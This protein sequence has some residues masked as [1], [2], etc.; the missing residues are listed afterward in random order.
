MFGGSNSGAVEDTVV[1]G[2]GD[3]LHRCVVNEVGIESVF[4]TG[5]KKHVVNMC[6]RYAVI[7]ELV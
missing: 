4:E 5:I 2:L 6:P 7:K 1:A 3:V